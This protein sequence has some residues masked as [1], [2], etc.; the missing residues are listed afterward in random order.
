M[1]YLPSYDEKMI[2]LRS[3][4]LKSLLSEHAFG[5]SNKRKAAVQTENH[6]VS[7]QFRTANQTSMRQTKNHCFCIDA[8]PRIAPIKLP[9]TNL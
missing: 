2:R 7:R 3:H 1:S 9:V 4:Y 8:H 5:W 6:K